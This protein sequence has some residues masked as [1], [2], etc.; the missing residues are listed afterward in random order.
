MTDKIVERRGTKPNRNYSL[1]ELLPNSLTSSPAVSVRTF[2]KVIGTAS[3]LPHH[4]ETFTDSL[5]VTR[6]DKPVGII[7]SIEILEGS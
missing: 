2:D 3:L 5:V 6:D 7:G 1:E 4:L